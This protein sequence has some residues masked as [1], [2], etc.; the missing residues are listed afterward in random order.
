MARITALLTV[1]TRTL[2]LKEGRQGGEKQ[3]EEKRAEGTSQQRFKEGPWAR[4]Q[5]FHVHLIGQKHGLRNGLGR[6]CTES[7]AGSL[8][9]LEEGICDKR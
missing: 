5:A 6:S 7:K 9:T 1:T 2:F 8:L 3:G 4:P